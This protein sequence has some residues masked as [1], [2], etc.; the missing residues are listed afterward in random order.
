MNCEMK[1]VILVDDDATLR[2]GIKTLVDWRQHGYLWAGEAK[3]GAQALE[4]IHDCQPDIVI[5][6]MKMPG[7][8]GIALI[9]EIRKQTPAPY[10]IALSSY[11]DFPLVREAMKLGAADYL[12][13]LELTPAVLLQSL[14]KAPLLHDAVDSQEIER[15]MQQ[16]R[17]LRDLI[18]RFYL[19]E[20]EIGTRLK[21]A[22][23]EFTEADV[24]CMLVK[25]EDLFLFEESTEEEYHTLTFSIRN[26][27]A[28]IIEDCMHAYYADGKTGELYIFCEIKQ[29]V[30]EHQPDEIAGE[31]ARRCRTMLMQY[32]DIRCVV[33]IGKGNRT[34]G[35]LAVACLQAAD[36]V[37]SRFYADGDG[38]LWWKGPC[39][40][41]VEELPSSIYAV[42]QQMIKGLEIR[43]TQAVREAI[44]SV[45]EWIGGKY[46][47][48]NVV[49][50]MIIELTG[51]VREYFERYGMEMEDFLSDSRHDF[52]KLSDFQTISEVLAWLNVLENE[53]VA[54]IGQE[55]SRSTL[56]VV[57]QVE[58]MLQ[59]RFSGEI[60]LTEVAQALGMTPGYISALMKKH[61]G[62]RFSEYLTRL[63][64]EKAKE[65]LAN[66]DWKV[67]AVA[68]AVGYEDAFYFSR[69]FKRIMGV[70]PGD[71][72]KNAA[73]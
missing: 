18:C 10:I 65:L 22:G 19:D 30:R 68:A 69:L 48:R 23:I 60:G 51:A 54:Y 33:G 12:L 66:T 27:V 3:D 32:L 45:K 29:P 35:G 40:E 17:A 5:T 21:D 44:A 67:Y 55:R 26:I 63:R 15:E 39:P 38:V 11:D 31:V 24:F 1:K 25:V 2:I 36:A 34:A 52:T 56:S 53:L 57:H 37:R 7:M 42:R 50:A 20:A 14:S 8:D 28:E 13:K 43:D 49:F 58:E 62:M 70:S 41:T 61:T 4:L 72:R 16:E 6:D 59:E 71:W 64:I 9:R 46:F 73:K 47:S